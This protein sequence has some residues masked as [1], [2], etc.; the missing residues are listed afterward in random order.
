MRALP[1]GDP[2]A[3]GYR[4]LFYCRYADDRLLGSRAE[5]RSRADQGR[6]GRVLRET[7]A[8]ELNASKTLDHPRPHPRGAVSRLPDTVQ[9]SS[10]PLTK[11]RRTVNGKV[12]LQVRR[13]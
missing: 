1:Y 10:T 2:M 11:G 9:H 4:R 5:D 12:A 8:L 13:T 3:P 6:A 7:L